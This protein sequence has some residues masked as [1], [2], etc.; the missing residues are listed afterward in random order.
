M[1]PGFLPLPR[2]LDGE[3]GCELP[4]FT[5]QLLLCHI[6]LVLFPAGPPGSGPKCVQEI[7]IPPEPSLNGSLGP[8][9]P[10]PIRW[11]GGLRF[12]IRNSC[13]IDNQLAILLATARENPGLLPRL[14]ES[15]IGSEN[16]L[17]HALQYLN[18]SDADK[19]KDTWVD[20]LISSNCVKVRA[21]NEANLYGGPLDMF[22]HHFCH[23]YKVRFVSECSN[24]SSCP[25]FRYTGTSTK[26]VRLVSPVTDGGCEA[27]VQT[28]R[29]FEYGYSMPCS[30]RVARAEN[31]T[32]CEFRER[33]K[34]VDICPVEPNEPIGYD[35]E[36]NGMRSFT[37]LRLAGDCWMLPLDITGMLLADALRL[38]DELTASG[39][40][41]CLRGVIVLDHN[42]AHFVSYIRSR[43]RWFFYCGQ[44]TPKGRV[45]AKPKQGA[46][47]LAL[48]TI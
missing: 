36:C 26:L 2:F 34:V 48:Y 9:L 22:F 27:Q 17:G 25:R 40:C 39:I 8:L 4:S 19:A 7:A 5:L 15:K 43:G 33:S 21:G 10:T 12:K 37:K 47:Q 18:N 14:L 29:S 6:A 1:L 16:A 35:F 28:T 46:P 45:I 44:V 20:H 24:D 30:E 23:V 11:E 3:G 13:T 32:F 41:F 31:E 42:K 38:P